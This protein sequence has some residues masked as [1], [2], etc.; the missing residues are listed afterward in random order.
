L[1]Q[2][3]EAFASKD[4]TDEIEKAR[5]ELATTQKS[6]RQGNTAATPLFRTRDEAAN[7]IGSQPDPENPPSL[8][9]LREM[10]EDREDSVGNDENI[11]QA[12]GLLSGFD[13]V[14]SE[15]MNS[16]FA[17][18]MR[19]A[20]DSL[21]APST[22]IRFAK[23]LVQ[24]KPVQGVDATSGTVADSVRQSASTNDSE[25]DDLDGDGPDGEDE[26]AAENDDDEDD[27]DEDDE[28]K[29]NLQL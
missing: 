8:N 16:S 21:A 22:G 20:H 6:I 13:S 4:A 18:P 17:S 9:A 7:A 26:L 28:E 10:H 1:D 11:K 5:E 29:K 3:N 19:D 2:G 24:D 25:D 27:D 14:A 23:Q 12:T 15:T